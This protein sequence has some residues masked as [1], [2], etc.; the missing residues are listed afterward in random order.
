MSDEASP[1]PEERATG[2]PFDEAIIEKLRE[3]VNA[4]LAEHPELRSVAIALDFN[5]RLNATQ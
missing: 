1:P 4:C 2:L 5:G 3:T